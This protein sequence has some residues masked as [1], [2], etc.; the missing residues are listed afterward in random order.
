VNA[1][2]FRIDHGSD[3]VAAIVNAAAQRAE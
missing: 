3:I 1:P 2:L